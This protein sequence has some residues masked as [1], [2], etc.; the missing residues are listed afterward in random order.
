MR[1][2]A[3]ITWIILHLIALGVAAAGWP[4]WAHH[5]QPREALAAHVTIVVEMAASAILWPLLF[6][7]SLTAAVQVLL[8]WPF[9][10]LA[11]LLGDVREPPLLVASTYVSIW[12]IGLAVLNAALPSRSAK[13]T[14]TTITAAFVLGGLV[15]AYLWS[16]SSL[17]TLTNSIALGPL[18]GALAVLNG[19][20][21]WFVWLEA[22]LPLLVAATILSLAR[23][24]RIWPRYTSEVG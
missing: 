10:Q 23:S 9:I 19:A 22:A 24:R 21:R 1:I 14:V 13:Q 5:L 6:S 15:I 8:V 7:T 4:L 2:G 17:K 16:E 20:A 12:M 3:L 18:L 11:G